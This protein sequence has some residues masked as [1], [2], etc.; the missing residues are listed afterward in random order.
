MAARP[1]NAHQAH[2]LRLLRDGGPRSRAE[3]GD[4]VDLSR[5]KVAVELDRLLELRLIE[6]AG[7]AASR[8]G[9]RSSLVQLAS[10]LRFVGIDIG[11]TSVDV[12]LTNGTLDV[13]AHL[14][15]PLDVRRGPR[16]VLERALALVGKV[17]AGDSHVEVHG[18]GVG[19]PGPVS[20]SDGVR[21]AAPIMPGWDRFPVR[22]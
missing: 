3:L 10:D 2:L 9:R 16:V 19:V 14:S 7:L 15:E 12:A 5:S 21:V 8:G 1:E 4:A 17:R 18:A 6:N 22:E 13:L 11:A 20:S